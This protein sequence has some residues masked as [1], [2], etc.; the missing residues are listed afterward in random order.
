LT[1]CSNNWEL[2][3]F[4]KRTASTVL[5]KNSGKDVQKDRKESQLRKLQLK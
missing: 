5:F 1:N 2:D 3:E 4:A